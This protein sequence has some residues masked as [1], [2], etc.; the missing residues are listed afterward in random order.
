MH[1]FIGR[2]VCAA[3]WDVVTPAVEFIRPLWLRLTGKP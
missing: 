2:L 3:V 1:T